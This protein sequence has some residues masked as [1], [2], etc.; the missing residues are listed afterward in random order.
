M[1]KTFF[2]HTLGLTSSHSVE[3]ALEHAVKVD[4][5]VF[6][7]LPDRRGKKEPVNKF[8]DEYRDM[9]VAHI[10]TYRPQVSHYRREHAPNRRYLPSDPSVADM[11][12]NFNA[13]HE[14]QCSYTYYHHIL[15]SMNISFSSPENDLCKRCFS[16]EKA[17]PTPQLSPTQAAE[18]SQHSCLECGC[19]SCDE[20]YEEHKRH[21]REARECLRDDTEKMQAS[22]NDIIVTTVDMQK[23]ISMPKVPIKDYYFHVT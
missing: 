15:T 22:Q 10:E 18:T 12:K 1:C 20:G 2:L 5:V 23:A 4:D 16:H 8:P 11:H 9:V 13:T 17:H 19:E 6:G 7:T 3:V 14:T 21:A